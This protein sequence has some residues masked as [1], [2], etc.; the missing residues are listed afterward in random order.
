MAE[1]Y[2]YLMLPRQRHFVTAGK[3]EHSNDHAGVSIGRFVYGRS[4]LERT[5]A[6]ALDP[7]ELTLARG[8]F[9]TTALKGVFGAIRDA[10]PDYW[11]RR[12]IERHVGQ[13]VLGELDYLLQSPDDRAGALAFG[14]NQQ[15]PA[16]RREFNKTI[17]LEHLQVIADAI[18][19]DEELPASS[20]AAQVQELVLIG[21]SMGGAR[22]KAVVEDDDGLWIAKFNRPDD[23]WN[24]A[25]VEHAMLILAR[26]CGLTTA[27]SKVIRVADRDVLLVKRFDR[28]RADD[29]YQRARM[30]SALTLLRAEDT[31]TDRGKWSYVSLAEE[32]RRASAEPER[33]A[34][35]LFLRMCFNALISNIDD[36]PCNHAII[37]FDRTWQLSPAYDLIPAT[38][39]SLERRDLAMSCGD[40]GRY[41]HA[42]NLVS[43]STRFLV[44]PSMA[45]PIVDEMEAQVRSTWYAVARAQGT[46]EKDCDRISRAFAYPGFRLPLNPG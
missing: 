24:S 10:S 37:A 39:V 46:S 16:P 31:N 26:N 7:V 5:D 33:D 6:V 36:H 40:L 45:K 20:D 1:C 9:R 35:Q 12:V 17:Q 42:D 14:L 15:P 44:P 38:P 43:Q 29:G 22:P 11:G 28:Q 8:T 21:T 13:P 23:P 32:L 25:R 41:A 27:E 19:R 2:V 30:V 34:H 18:V 4:Y 3:F